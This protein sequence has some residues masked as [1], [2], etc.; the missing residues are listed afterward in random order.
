MVRVPKRGVL[1]TN[2]Q[3]WVKPFCSP[4]D[5]LLRNQQLNYNIVI[6]YYRYSLLFNWLILLLF[7]F[8]VT[9]NEQTIN[10]W[11]GKILPLYFKLNLRNTFEIVEMAFIW[12]PKLYVFSEKNLL[13][14]NQFCWTLY[15]KS[16]ALWWIRICI[17]WKKC[18]WMPHGSR[19]TV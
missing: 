19:Q 7:C 9:V 18:Q 14:M 13:L 16:K 8:Q 3:W 2:N 1:Q 6:Y 4:L 12:W 5:Y 11:T 17:Y 10:L 15:F